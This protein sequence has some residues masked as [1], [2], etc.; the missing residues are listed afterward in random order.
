MLDSVQD[1]ELALDEFAQK[2]VES[3]FLLPPA[4]LP[5][6]HRGGFPYLIMAP[7]A[8]CFSGWGFLLDGMLFQCVKARQVRNANCLCQSSRKAFGRAA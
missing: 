7:I 1:V 4:Q 3:K 6:R 8:I 5:P 2:S